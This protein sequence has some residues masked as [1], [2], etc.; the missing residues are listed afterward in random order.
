MSELEKLK[1]NL[2]VL[3]DTLNKF[4]NINTEINSVLRRR[5]ERKK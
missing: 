4:M 2:Q 3:E 5:Y 1:Q